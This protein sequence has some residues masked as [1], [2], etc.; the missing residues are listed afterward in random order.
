MEYKI[1]I[2][3]EANPIYV[4]DKVS[5][6]SLGGENAVDVIS[7]ELAIDT[8]SATL[9]YK[10]FTQLEFHSS[11]DDQI[12]TFDNKI[13]CCTNEGNNITS[14]AYG[15]SILLYSSL[16]NVDTLVNRF[17][18]EEVKRVSQ[19]VYSIGAMSIIGLFDTQYHKGGV[20]TGETISDIL[21]EIFGGNRFVGQ[22]IDII[23]GEIETVV[24]NENIR[25]IKM[26]GYLPY[27]SKRSNLHKLLFAVGAVIKR[28]SATLVVSALESGEALEIMSKDIFIGNTEDCSSVVTGVEIVEHTY[29]WAYN[30]QMV[31]LYNNT[32]AYAESASNVLV[33]FSEPIKIE[34]AVCEGSLS[35]SELG[36]NYA[37]VSGRGILKGIPY[38]HITRSISKNNG[39]VPSSIS[40]VSDCTLISPLN[41]ENVLLRLYDYFVESREQSISTKLA[42]LVPGAKYTF[43]NQFNETVYGW[44]S[45]I[46]FNVSSFIKS[47]CSF[48]TKFSSNYLG[49]N[50][51]NSELFTGASTWEVPTS[52]RNSDFP[53]IR[54]VLIGGG[55]GGQGGFG[56]K[57][58]RGCYVKN[59]VWNG[60]GGGKGGAAGKGGIAGEGARV[61]SI[62]KLDVSLVA[63]IVY[64]CGSGGT[65]GT[66]G[67]GGY[68]DIDPVDAS[69]GLD[70]SDTVLHFLDDAGN[71]LF[72]YTTA[73]GSIMPSGVIDLVQ[74]K[75]F[76]L[77]GI[78]GVSGGDGGEGGCAAFGASG[79]DG[80]S[81]DYKGIRY[82]GGKF[83]ES[84]YSTI[85][86]T[87][88]QAFC[89]G[90]GGGGAAVGANG[91]DAQTP[92]RAQAN[93]YVW[94]GDA[95]NGADAAITPSVSAFYGQG[96]DGG[97]GGGG[98]GS[99]GAQNWREQ[100]STGQAS[101]IHDGLL[102]V[103]GDGT[104]GAPGAPGCW[105]CYY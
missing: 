89:G 68:E 67:I 77:S 53:Y 24:V 103:G 1:K 91:Q 100:T 72:F 40:H 6:Q 47:R 30:S 21:L 94:G 26:Y 7:N 44:L 74:N 13:F 20:Y 97:H 64:S 98:G 81:V 58:G 104:D 83:S 32:D 16:N 49:N 35:Y 33:I 46:E 9:R 54:I 82:T 86:G 17:Y 36:Q 38:T 51:N 61:L 73:N 60:H 34:S 37:I 14:L 2:G 96:G 88:L 23:Y 43:M 10:F 71:E 92:G 90:A 99:G 11:E 45:K 56:G 18:L 85:V 25:G 3:S 59:K 22:N 66:K 27:A 95:G 5:I 80:E 31:E 87:Q 78:D 69:L 65:A 50:Y 4:F 48:I 101:N 79:F 63:T 76:G 42:G 75:V 105:F 55:Q 70:G 8:L 15:T 84:L 19:D 12:I 93:A 39:K 102:G 62:A 41:S 29:Q 28:T 57:Q 52:V